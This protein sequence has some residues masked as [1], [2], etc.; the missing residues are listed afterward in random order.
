MGII[1]RILG[2]DTRY[3][4]VTSVDTSTA[5]KSWRQKK[6]NSFITNC[7]EFSLGDISVSISGV[8]EI[9]ATI[10]IWALEKV[11]GQ[12]G[13]SFTHSVMYTSLLPEGALTVPFV[14]SI[15]EKKYSVYFIYTEEQLLKYNDLVK[16]VTDTAYPELIYFS[17]MPMNVGIDTRPIIEPFQLADLVVDKEWQAVGDFAMW[18]PT[19]EDPVFHQS[20]TCEYLSNLYKLVN[21]Y[22]SYATGYVLRQ[23]GIKSESELERILL[24]ENYNTYVLDAPEAQKVLLDLSQESGIR[25]LFPIA[26]VTREYR[27]RFLKGVFVDLASTI[28]P[29]RQQQ[30]P[31]DNQ[32]MANGSDWFTRMAETVA[33]AE[34]NGDFIGPHHVGHIEI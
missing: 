23:T 19:P 21:R 15:G 27:E 2:Y 32:T 31:A 6:I 34:Q 4:S 1:G 18:W 29:L 17:V 25:F 8:L 22:E 24:P 16:Q 12:R 10:A 3:Q 5:A 11:A 33:H 26:H 14:C 20:A 7:S 9:D 30:T 28:I 13:V